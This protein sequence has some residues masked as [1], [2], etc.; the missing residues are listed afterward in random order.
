MLEKIISGWNSNPDF[1]KNCNWRIEQE[2]PGHYFDFPP[3][4]SHV[5]KSTL[6]E[7]GIQALYAHQLQSWEAVK[8]GKHIVVVT[9]TASGKTLCYNLPILDTL[10]HD[11]N[12]RA[13]YIFPTKALAQDQKQSLTNILSLAERSLQFSLTDLI[14]IYD[15]DTPQARRTEIR[16]TTRLLFTNPDMLHTAILPHHTLWADFFSNLKYIVI[17]EIHTYRGVF[18]SHVANVIRRLKRIAMFYGSQPLFILTSATIA[19]PLELSNRLIGE[20]V[21]LIDED[22]SPKGKKH[23]ILYNP[24]F[25]NAPLGIRVG[26]M[27]ESVRIVSDIIGHNI[28][29]LMFTRSRRSVEHIL[30]YLKP[31][32]DSKPGQLRG[33]RSGYT[34]K[35]RRQIENGLRAG[36]IRGVIATT[37][38]ELGIDIGGIDAVIIVGYPGSIAAIRQQAGRAGRKTS[39]GLAIL[40]LSNSPLDQYLAQNPDFIFKT[41]PEKAL[42]NPDNLLILLHHL[43]CAAFELPFKEKDY[44]GTLDQSTLHALLA[45]LVDEGVLY[46]SGSKYYWMADKYPA[47]DVSLRTATAD[48]VLLVMENEVGKK[49]IGQIDKISAHW[50]VHP[51]AVYLHEWDSYLVQDLDLENNI[52]Y[53]KP[54]DQ[55]YYTEPRRQDSIECLN[56]M[57]EMPVEGGQKSYGE[58]LVTT[59]LVGY[60]KIQWSTNAFLGNTELPLPPTTLRTTAFWLSLSENTVEQ[61]LDSGIWRSAPNDYGKSWPRIR[62]QIRKRDGFQCQGCGALEQNQPFHVHHKIPFKLFALPETAN[63]PDNLITLCPRCHKAAELSV[64]VRSGLAGLSYLFHHLAP[65]FLMCDL[66]DLGSHIEYKCAFANHQPAVIIFEQIPAGIGLCEELFSIYTPL[67]KS[68]LNR[69]QECAC[70]GGCPGCVGPSGINDSGAKTETT[71]ILNALANNQQD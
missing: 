44:F 61:L 37:A 6:Q 34:A 71:A 46:A 10:F 62:D 11:P 48:S 32:S 70:A 15:G 36:S 12:L 9:A 56:I 53:L 40:V 49:I 55:D 43:R 57:K 38:L 21:S 8:N 17:D 3:T 28:Q 22:G 65:L 35:E 67:I 1:I 5:I 69:V 41:S 39:E 23:F 42:I 18:G 24:P 68:A 7:M 60:K 30:R 52:A 31:I 58:I 59:Q 64:R 16:Q 26:S 45:F 33:Y 50:M 66:N 27:T 63:H 2:C 29:F 25:L 20:N 47:Q 14:G 51:G 4:I 19:N 13:L 54:F